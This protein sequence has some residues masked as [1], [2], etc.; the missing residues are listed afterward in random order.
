M[1]LHALTFAVLTKNLV[2]SPIAVLSLENR[3]YIIKKYI[4]CIQ[5]S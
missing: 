1:D 3:L 4:K 5:I 2:L